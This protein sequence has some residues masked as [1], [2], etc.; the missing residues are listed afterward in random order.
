MPEQRTQYGDEVRWGMMDEKS[1]AELGAAIV[2]LVEACHYTFSIEYQ[3]ADSQGPETWWPD[4]YTVTIGNEWYR[5]VSATSQV[6]SDA[7]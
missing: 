1:R 6:L 2:E 4:S 7:L 3:A 5:E